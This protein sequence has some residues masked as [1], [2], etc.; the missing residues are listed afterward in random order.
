MI[1]LFHH[2][3]SY[4][5]FSSIR[6]SW[7]CLVVAPFIGCDKFWH[8]LYK[9]EECFAKPFFFLRFKNVSTNEFVFLICFLNSE[10]NCF[11]A[12]YLNQN[13][14]IYQFHLGFID[15]RYK[16]ECIVGPMV[17]LSLPI[18]CS[19]TH[20]Y[21][22]T[23]PFTKTFKNI[24]PIWI[25]DSGFFSLLENVSS[26]KYDWIVLKHIY[27]GMQSKF[28][29]CSSLH[30]VWKR[31]VVPYGGTSPPKNVVFY[32]SK[33]FWLSLYKEY[34]DYT[35]YGYT[36]YWFDVIKNEWGFSFVPINDI[37]YMLLAI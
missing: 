25:G 18:E 32:K 35:Q 28:Y 11:V 13:G 4:L 3:S 15:S 33:L 9:M 7:T 16:V 23:S 5:E 30:R 31:D 36:I 6:S 17:V 24:G 27:N 37:H 21:F 26:E 34:E 19:Q 29:V 20:N 10:D 8:Y 1:S 14:H 22:V 2:G 12:Q